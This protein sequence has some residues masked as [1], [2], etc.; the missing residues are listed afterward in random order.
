MPKVEHPHQPIT[1]TTLSKVNLSDHTYL[2]SPF[3]SSE[4]G[5]SI[6]LAIKYQSESD[7]L[8]TRGLDYQ[9]SLMQGSLNILIKEAQNLQFNITTPNTIGSTFCKL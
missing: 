8:S 5:G 7:P 6:F 9:Q 1:T 4:C 3:K 2:S